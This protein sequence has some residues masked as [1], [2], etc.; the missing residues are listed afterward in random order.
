MSV[1]VSKIIIS[2]ALIGFFVCTAGAGDEAGAALKQINK[3]TKGIRGLVAEV[4]YSEIVG[5]RS[6]DGRGKL[7]VSF[8]GLMRVEVAGDDPRTVLFSPPY[9]YIHRESDQVVDFFDITS[10]PHRLGQYVL[11]GFVPIGSAMKKHYT[12]EL[13]PNAKLDERPVPSFLLTPKDKQ[14][15][16]AIARIQLWVDPESGL[17]LQQQIFHAISDT[18]LV[19]R[20]LSTTRND[21]LSPE[22]FSP[23]WPAGTTT[24]RR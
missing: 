9:L 6:I 5:K 1:R 21:E 14:V 8:V 23:Q 15:A 7:Y 10:N 20:Y 2:W 24:I 16:R 13:V 17:P 12:V 19:V 22:L 3:A 18:R 11:L 4:Q